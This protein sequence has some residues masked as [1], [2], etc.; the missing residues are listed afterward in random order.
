MGIASFTVFPYE[1]ACAAV[2]PA[3][4]SNEALNNDLHHLC[5]DLDPWT[6]SGHGQ[7]S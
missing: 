5:R 6:H 1:V 4:K 3:L 7:T 2:A